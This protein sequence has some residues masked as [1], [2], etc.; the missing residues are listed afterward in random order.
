MNID[1]NKYEKE[2]QALYGKRVRLVASLTI[3]TGL[4][5]KTNAAMLLGQPRV[6]VRWGDGNVAHFNLADLEVIPP[7][8]ETFEGQRP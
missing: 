7:F 8:N 4:V 3:R 1:R 2:K 6:S 5:T